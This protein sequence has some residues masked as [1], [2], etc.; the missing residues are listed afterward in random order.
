MYALPQLAP[1]RAPITG[2]EGFPMTTKARVNHVANVDRDP[3]MDPR[4]NPACANEDPE[5]FFPVGREGLWDMALVADAR[6]I[7]SRCPVLVKCHDWAMESGEPNGIVAGRTPNERKALK[8]K[9]DQDAK[10]TAQ[11]KLL[12]ELL[13]ERA[14]DPDALLKEFVH[15]PMPIAAWAE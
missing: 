2:R 15:P 8:R 10:D 9:A 5:L 1:D 12:G 13:A 7:C 4:N 14:G 6:E 3:R 11:R